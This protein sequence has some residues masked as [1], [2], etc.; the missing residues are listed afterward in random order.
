MLQVLC[1][2]DGTLTH[3]VIKNMTYPDKDVSC[4]ELGEFKQ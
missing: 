3:D 4:E 2:H 1:K